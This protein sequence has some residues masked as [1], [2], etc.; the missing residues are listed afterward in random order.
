MKKY[1]GLDAHSSTCTFCVMNEKGV[2][3]DN[4]TIRTNGRLLVNYLKSIKGDTTLTFE[5]CELSSWLY[6]ILVKEVDA[7]LV[8]NP[9]YNKEYKTRK[10]DRLDARK[11]AKLLRGDFLTPVFHDGS[12]RE[13]FRDLMSAYTDLVEE[14]TRIKL[15]YKSLFRKSGNKV[16]GEKL[17]TDESF[18]KD[19]KRKDYNFIGKSLYHLL[20]EM[21][22]TRE[23]YKKEIIKTSKRFEEI[24]KLK[25]LPGI[26]AIR[27]AHISAQVINPR[28]FASKYQSYNYCGL[29][30]HK[31]ISGGREYGSRKIWG[32]RVLKCVYKMASHDAIRGNNKLSKYYESLRKKGVN[33]K[34]ARNAVSRK[35][36]AISLS[37]WRNNSD[38]NESKVT[39]AI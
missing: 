7:V 28:R 23:R 1:I 22:E 25:S 37:I 13:K 26:G 31:Q 38:Y 10:T 15:R 5:E 16:S 6:E 20:Q 33:D 39:I 19:L 14:A 36:A 32:N 2:E 4:T 30:R 17:Y 27:A 21:E 9:V 18:L 11:L 8:C 35:I 29:V 24:R 34:S 12:S 3:L